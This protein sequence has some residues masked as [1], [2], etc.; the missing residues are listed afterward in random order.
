MRKQDPAI[1]PTWTGALV[2]APNVAVPSEAEDSRGKDCLVESG[3]STEFLQLFYAALELSGVRYCLLHA[4]EYQYEGLKSDL[5]IAVAPQDQN[6]L[7]NVFSQLRASGFRPI[8]ATRYAP[9]S[10]A[11]VFSWIRNGSVQAI[12]ID[13]TFQ[14]WF[15]GR[16]FPLIQRILDGR[17]KYKSRW[18]ASAEDEFAYLLTKRLWKTEVSAEQAE[19][20][21]RL[22]ESIGHE[23]ALAISSQVM[24]AKL[25]E[26]LVAAASLDMVRLI[27]RRAGKSVFWKNV[28]EHPVVFAKYVLKELRR[29]L[30]RTLRTTGLMVAFLGPDGAGKSTLIQEIGPA[31]GPV[32]RASSVFHLRPMF[33]FSRKGKSPVLNPHGKPPRGAFSSSLYLTAF[34]F[35]Y[36]LG[37]LFVIRPSLVRSSFI[38][39]DRYFQDV[40]V[41]PFRFRFG[42]PRWL[43]RAFAKLVPAPDLVFILNADE[44]LMFSRKG[45][46]PVAELKRQGQEYSELKFSRSLICTIATSGVLD[47][48]VGMCAESVA[49]FLARRFGIQN[50]EWQDQVV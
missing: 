42:G 46:L 29:G 1:T 22:I 31:L 8:Q 19:R 5:D 13:V 4:E 3:S 15:H 6:N 47:R 12:S 24:P 48:T 27:V 23:R 41:D 7:K 26:R 35:D 39:F 21:R 11:F 34:L 10:I 30:L 50:P 14:P 20:L 37:Y 45:E 32:F 44:Q 40:I 36:W 17:R 25:A 43:S 49:D 28:S 18:I 9:D 33:L 16:A 38:L 2:T